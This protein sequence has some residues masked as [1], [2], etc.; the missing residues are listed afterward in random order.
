MVPATANTPRFVSA[1]Q[2]LTAPTFQS[3]FASNHFR[4]ATIVRGANRDTR[5][6]RLRKHL[7]TPMGFLYLPKRQALASTSTIITGLPAPIMSPQRSLAV[8]LRNEPAAHPAVVASPQGPTRLHQET[9]LQTCPL[10][11]QTCPS[12]IGVLPGWNCYSARYSCA[13]LPLSRSVRAGSL[14]Y[15]A[16]FG[17]AVLEIIPLRLCIGPIFA[18]RWLRRVGLDRQRATL[19]RKL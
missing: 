19:L 15:I 17:N 18:P 12:S 1:I 4:M 13:V 6:W 11:L 8:F 5:G 16:A 7:H 14:R 9:T 10:T 3:I 2:P